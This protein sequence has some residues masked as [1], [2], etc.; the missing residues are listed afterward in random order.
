MAKWKTIE[1]NA[2]EAFAV[3]WILFIAIW[4]FTDTSFFL[5][6]G[7]GFI[8]A[9]VVVHF[10]A[11]SEEK[12]RIAREDE[13]SAI[14][15]DVRNTSLDIVTNYVIQHLETLV[16][17]RRTLVRTGD[18][19]EVV[20][21]AWRK[22][23]DKFLEVVVTPSVYMMAIDNDKNNYQILSNMIDGL[24][25][26]NEHHVDGFS[27]QD[28]EDLDGVGY[29]LYCAELLEACGWEVSR[30]PTSGDHGVDL[31]AE[32]FGRKVAI[33]CKKYS[34]PVGNKAVQEAYSGK[35]FYDAGEAVVVS[36]ASFTPAAKQLAGKLSVVLMHQAQLKNL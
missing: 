2:S 5:M 13:I 21:G 33:Q 20:D 19:G 9:Y 35:S 24:V 7:G 23:I 1:T 17:K 8:V 6:V 14:N 3:T 28:V 34:S 27:D 25:A 4:W 31:I 10:V 30:T 36:N 22:E 12:E 11:K 18:Y 29:E 16:R 26:D 15:R 32:K